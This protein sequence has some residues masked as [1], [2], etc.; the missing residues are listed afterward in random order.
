MQLFIFAPVK[1]FAQSL[2]HECHLVA[3]GLE[4]QVVTKALRNATPNIP[5]SIPKNPYFT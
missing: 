1:I 5:R 3:I 4:R 2:F